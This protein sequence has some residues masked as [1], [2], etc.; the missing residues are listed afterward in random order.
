MD[1]YE[2]SQRD[3]REAW[4]KATVADPGL[5][6]VHYRPALPGRDGDYCGARKRASRAGACYFRVQTTTN[7]QKTTCPD[8]RHAIGNIVDYWRTHI[9]AKQA[10][11]AEGEGG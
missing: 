6:M 11:D 1:L 2:Q 10:A 8:C 4:A 3:D 7:V 5:L 9:T